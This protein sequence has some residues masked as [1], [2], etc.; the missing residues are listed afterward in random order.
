MKENGK[1]S[2]QK[3]YDQ[4]LDQ[5]LLI[6]ELAYWTHVSNNGSFD[7]DL[8]EYALHQINLLHSNLGEFKPISQFKR[9]NQG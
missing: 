9:Y 7:A 3:P 6:E 5:S 2:Q 4:M 1:L 8:K